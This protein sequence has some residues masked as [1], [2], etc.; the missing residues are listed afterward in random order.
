MAWSFKN[1]FKNK[2]EEE[3]EE[4]IDEN[5]TSTCY[6]IGT[7]FTRFFLLINA[8]VS[9]SAVF[10]AYSLRTTE[11][12]VFKYDES[13]KTLRVPLQSC[14]QPEID[15]VSSSGSTEKISGI[16]TKCIGLDRLVSGVG[17][18]LLFSA[19]AS[20]TYL[21]IIIA[22]WSQGRCSCCSKKDEDAV[23]T[24]NS[25]SVKGML[26]F[27]IFILI[28]TA[29]SSRSL[30]EQLRFTVNFYKDLMEERGRS[31][32]QNIKSYGNSSIFMACTVL[33]SLMVI[34]I[35]INF[36]HYLLCRKPRPP[37]EEEEEKE[38]D[39]EDKK[40]NKDEKEN[41]NNNNKSNNKDEKEDDKSQ[42]SYKERKPTKGK[43]RPPSP[44]PAR[45]PSPPPAVDDDDDDSFI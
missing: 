22:I 34:I 38:V 26:V 45:P 15:I 36:F 1:S 19:L 5:A 24:F 23:P 40:S 8:L 7:Y 41:D 16:E 43:Q 21:G 2:V 27:L 3:E 20:F 6:K 9:L 28:Q 11:G 17:M 18:G 30:S 31:E 14:S 4:E 13:T 37:K 10:D 39:E 42:D 12:A 44:P 35:F 29:I 32:F 25:K 33:N